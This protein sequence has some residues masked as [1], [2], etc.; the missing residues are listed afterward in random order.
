MRSKNGFTLIELLITITIMAVLLTLTVVSLRSSQAVARDE[1]RRTDVAAIAQSLENYFNGDINTDASVESAMVSPSASFASFTFNQPNMPSIKLA[2]AGST[3]YYYQEG[4]YPPTAYF[5]NEQSIKNAL[6]S[7]DVAAI[8]APG[9]ADSES[10]SLIGATGTGTQSPTISQYIYQ[11][12]KADGTLCNVG[13]T[14]SGS[15]DLCREFT[16][17]YRLETESGVKSI[18]SKRR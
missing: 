12:L 17:Y 16:L 10:P 5:N 2:A 11:P 6:I 4:Y 1:E 15:K 18:T 13:T 8:R 9:V 14:P 3:Y 7:L